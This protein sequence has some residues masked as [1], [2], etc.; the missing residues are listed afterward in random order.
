MLLVASIPPTLQFFVEVE[1]VK[2]LT[3]RFMMLFL[4]GLSLYFGVI[5]PMIVLGLLN[6]RPPRDWCSLFRGRDGMEKMFG[7]IVFRVIVLVSSYLVL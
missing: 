2:I 6:S 5:R 4:F 7:L 1:V 3:E